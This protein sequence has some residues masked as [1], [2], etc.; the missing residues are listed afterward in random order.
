MSKEKR[1]RLS[2]LPPTDAR[3]VYQEA[4]ESGDA[5]RIAEAR[6]FTVYASMLVA[7]FHI[8]KM[9][10]EHG[11]PAVALFF[12]CLFVIITFLDSLAR[13]GKNYDINKVIEVFLK[14]ISD[15]EGNPEAE[16]ELYKHMDKLLDLLPSGPKW[17]QNRGDG[18]G[19]S[20]LH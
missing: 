15:P 9:S 11:T 18:G 4:L 8:D 16:Q 7:G 2:E 10:R 17:P 12:A 13:E 20:M 14:Y 6:G 3:R 1:Q 19:G 5:E